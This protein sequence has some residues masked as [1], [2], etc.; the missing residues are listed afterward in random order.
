MTE[1][2]NRLGETAGNAGN[3]PTE[4]TDVSPHPWRRYIART[5]DNLVLGSLTWMLIYAAILL[6]TPAATAD[7][8]FAALDRPEARL[9]NIVVT[10]ILVIPGNALMIGLTGVSLGKWIFGVRVSKDGAPIGVVRAL[11]RELG[12][13]SLGQ[14]LG[15][16]VLSLILPLLAFNR[17]QSGKAAVWDRAQDLTVSY[18]PQSRSTTIWMWLAVVGAMALVMGIAALSKL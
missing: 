8:V 3:A 16:P 15:I 17:L 7:R 5:L 1:I 14:G 6:L 4:W 2:T 11:R 10:Q 9:V 12:V 13:Y 18:R